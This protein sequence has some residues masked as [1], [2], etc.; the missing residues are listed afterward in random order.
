MWKGTTCTRRFATWTFSTPAQQQITSMSEHDPS[1]HP[2]T[3]EVD[4]IYVLATKSPE[5]YGPAAPTKEHTV[6]DVYN[7]EARKVDIE[8]VKDWRESLNSLLLFVSYGYLLA[9]VD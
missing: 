9:S 1:K 5:N 7:N 6:W 2:T 8:L 4:E 3:N